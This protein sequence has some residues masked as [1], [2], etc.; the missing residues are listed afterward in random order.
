[1][2]S[3]I[4]T[5]ETFSILAPEGIANQINFELNNADREFLINNLI[6]DQEHYKSD[7]NGVVGADDIDHIARSFGAHYTVKV[8]LSRKQIQLR[9]TELE[10]LDE[11]Q[12]LS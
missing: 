5:N 8:H 7:A 10:F 6:R 4:F 3:V 1:M 2:D 11:N 12:L 9:I